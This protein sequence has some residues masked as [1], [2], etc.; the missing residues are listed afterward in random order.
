MSSLKDVAQAANVSVPT[1]SRILRR[2]NLTRFSAETRDRVWEAA[3]R[4]RYRP[5]MLVKGIQTGL[6]HTIGVMVRPFD[7]YWSSILY[8][9]HDMLISADYVPIIL[10]GRH[11]DDFGVNQPFDGLEQMHR[12]IDRRVD[13]AILW[14]PEVPEYYEHHKELASRNVPIVTIDHEL[15]IKYGSDSVATDEEQGA[16]LVADHLFKLGHRHVAHL[17]DVGLDTYSWALRRHT[18]FEQEIAKVPGTSCITSERIKEVDAIEIAKKILTSKPRPTAIY[19]ASDL[20]ARYVY[21]AAAELKLRIPEDVSV[22]G[23]ADLDFAPLMV[24]PLT[25]VRQKGY[26]IGCTASRL[27]LSRIQGKFIEGENQSIKMDCE[28]IVRGSTG[29]AP[30]KSP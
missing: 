17:G 11:R 15:P 21:L 10:W 3:A 4:L 18:Y 9:I 16:R 12:L 24:P 20:L 6:T 2:K 29:P 28:L 23:F 14:P 13:G 27:L 22:V 30:K 5:N 25:T 1:A 7:S 8:G 19:A 26:E